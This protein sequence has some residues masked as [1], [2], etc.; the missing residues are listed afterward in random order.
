MV[1]EE[2]KT[3]VEIGPGKTPLFDLLRPD[4]RGE[5]PYV[6]LERSKILQGRD[7]IKKMFPNAE[8]VRGDAT[9]MPFVKGS[10]SRF[11]S[12]DLFSSQA[13]YQD[14]EG[15]F[16]GGVDIGGIAREIKRTCQPG[17][18]IIIFEYSV[19]QN[20]DHRDLAKH[21]IG[22]FKKEGFNLEEEYLGERAGGLFREEAQEV[23]GRDSIGLVFS[24]P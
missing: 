5:G 22:F 11:F 21:L 13:I 8:P 18:K 16:H 6:L 14:D 20:V 17:G 2:T 4:L 10:V 9:N 12:K 7:Q 23:E 19:P 15:K 24:K 1:N 3:G